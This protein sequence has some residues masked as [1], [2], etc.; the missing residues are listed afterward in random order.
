MVQKDDQMA[1][2]FT[3]AT[4]AEGTRPGSEMGRNRARWPV[5]AGQRT[6]GRRATRV[7]KTR[8]ETRDSRIP[9]FLTT[10]I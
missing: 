2:R 8:L 10:V 3:T 6:H 9:D 1:S 5:W 7:Q 4:V